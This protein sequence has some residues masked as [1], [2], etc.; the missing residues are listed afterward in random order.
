MFF[1]FCFFTV[2]LLKNIKKGIINDCVLGN[3]FLRA[4][5]LC[6]REKSYSQHTIFFLGFSIMG[7]NRV[8]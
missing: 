8:R 3:N 1:C 6:G 2:V 5:I 4:D 7:N